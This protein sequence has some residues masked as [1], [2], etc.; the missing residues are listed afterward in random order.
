MKKVFSAIFALV[1][2]FFTLLAFV[3]CGKKEAEKTAKK[4]FSEKWDIVMSGE[5]AIEKIYVLGYDTTTPSSISDDFETFSWLCK[6]KTIQSAVEACKKLDADSVLPGGPV[7]IKDDVHYKN[8]T[9]SFY[10]HDNVR[11]MSLNVDYT[12]IVTISVY[13]EEKDVYVLHGNGIEYNDL[14]RFMGIF[15]SETSSAKLFT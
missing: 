13:S 2:C 3:G 14:E 1:L 8:Y 5:S 11:I 12:G 15:E 6:P 9:L 7:K 4:L 10:D